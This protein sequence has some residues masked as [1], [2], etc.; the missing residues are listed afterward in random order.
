MVNK[1]LKEINRMALLHHASLQGK[2]TLPIIQQPSESVLS[3]E[4]KEINNN[5]DM[6][7]ESNISR[8]SEREEK[9]LENIKVPDT[10]LFD[11]PSL[12]SLC[13]SEISCVKPEKEGCYLAL[14]QRKQVIRLDDKYM[15][16]MAENRGLFGDTTTTKTKS[17][18]SKKK[19]VVETIKK[20][21]KRSKTLEVYY[22][23]III[24]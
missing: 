5:D 4:I 21:K 3:V 1:A 9:I 22:S 8:M 17:S 10:D 6:N 23:I 18:K 11:S 13:P 15:I 14:L 16:Q 2:I 12:P 24:K 20:P 19:I 7:T